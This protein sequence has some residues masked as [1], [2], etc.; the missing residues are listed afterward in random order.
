MLSEGERD[1]GEAAADEGTEE[2]E[3]IAELAQGR[4]SERSNRW[5]F[6]VSETVI[7]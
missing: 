7:Q 4:S 5:S 1:E 6:F 2:E 3:R